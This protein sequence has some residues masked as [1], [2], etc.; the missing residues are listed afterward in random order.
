MYESEKTLFLF[1]VGR[2]VSHLV[3]LQAQLATPLPTLRDRATPTRRRRTL[4]S[5]S[6]NSILPPPS[7]PPTPLKRSTHNDDPFHLV[8]HHPLRFGIVTP[9]NSPSDGDFAFK[10]DID[11]LCKGGAHGGPP[12]GGVNAVYGMLIAASEGGV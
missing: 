5:P 9:E 6:S 2:T 10:D 1:V 3:G 4:G 12:P 11:F 7:L 8:S